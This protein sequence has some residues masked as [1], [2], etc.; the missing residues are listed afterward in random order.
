MIDA[1]MFRGNAAKGRK[2]GGKRDSIE[3]MTL[4]A[5]HN[6]REKVGSAHIK[7]KFFLDPPTHIVKRSF[8]FVRPSDSK[9]QVIFEQRV[10]PFF[11]C[12]SRKISLNKYILDPRI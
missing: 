8:P 3:T 4:T 12:E 7:V 9:S 11:T 1:K 6:S 2:K 10:W 5:R